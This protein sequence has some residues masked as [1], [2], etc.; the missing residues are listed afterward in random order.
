MATTLLELKEMVD[1][2]VYEEG[3]NAQH[4]IITDGRLI[5]KGILVILAG[6]FQNEGILQVAIT[7]EEVNK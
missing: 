2:I 1:Q 4:V 7:L 3:E 5:N 6:V